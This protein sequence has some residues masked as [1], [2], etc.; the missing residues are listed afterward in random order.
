MATATELLF[1]IPYNGKILF[2]RQLDLV[3]ELLNTSESAYYVEKADIE[4]Y[5][6]EATRLKTLVS[7]LLSTTVSRN[8]PPEFPSSLRAIIQKKIESPQL[9][10]Q[11]VKDILEDLKVKNESSKS[12][13][14]HL[15]AF[16]RLKSEFNAANYIAIITANPLEIEL[17]T[18]SDGFSLRKLFV[19]DFLTFISNP[20]EGLKKYRLLLPLESTCQLFWKGLKNI[21][22]TFIKRNQYDDSLMKLISERYAGQYNEPNLFNN[23]LPLDEYIERLTS[24]LITSLNN[25][26]NI[27]V[28]AHTTPLFNLPTIAI[29]PADTRHARIYSLQDSEKDEL[30]VHTYSINEA[31][32]WRIFVWDRIKTKQYSGK[33]IDFMTS[34]K[35]IAEDI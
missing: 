10:D 18:I 4:K 22:F 26:G 2:K 9:V 20:H 33:R 23:D 3:Q 27:V 13:T 29:N 5:E 8:V 30:Y 35:D 17:D 28:F 19:D 7:Q 25:E 1:G 21:V 32:L 34:M 11:I 6:R 12:H 15:S 16:D 31:V 24:S 14:K